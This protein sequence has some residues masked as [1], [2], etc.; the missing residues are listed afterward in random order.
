MKRRIISLPD[1]F[2]LAATNRS[3]VS[4]DAPNATRKKKFSARV[5]YTRLWPN[6]FAE[7]MSSNLSRRD[8]HRVLL[9]SIENITSF[10]NIR[11]G[12]YRRPK[13]KF[14]CVN[15]RIKFF[16]SMPNEINCSRVLPIGSRSFN[17]IFGNK[18]KRLYT[19][20]SFCVLNGRPYK[21]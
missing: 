10:M 8:C 4:G 14:I 19:D 18:A 5:G 17:E 20:I 13:T 12:S 9:I 3:W 11:R 7:M 21:W 15:N 16:T 6:V 2:P 1:L